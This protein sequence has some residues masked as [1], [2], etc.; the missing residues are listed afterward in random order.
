MI[1]DIVRDAW[2]T[3]A[4]CRMRVFGKLCEQFPE[5][6]ARKLEQSWVVEL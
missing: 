5:H 3:L 1:D 6:N 4:L 2:L